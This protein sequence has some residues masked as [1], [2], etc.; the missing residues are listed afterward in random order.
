MSGDAFVFLFPKSG[1]IY[2]RLEEWPIKPITLVSTL[3]FQFCSNEKAEEIEDFFAS[4]VKPSIART[5]KQSVERVQINAKWVQSI[6][7]E[8][9]LG[10]VVKELAHRKY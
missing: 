1:N 3:D 5:L 6:R 2:D 10:E 9:S 7:S 8:Q 4:Q